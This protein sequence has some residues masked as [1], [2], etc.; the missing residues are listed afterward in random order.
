MSAAINSADE[1]TQVYSRSPV[2]ASL[3]T[4]LVVSTLLLYD[5]GKPF[6][7]HRFH[8]YLMLRYYPQVLNFDKEVDIL[9]APIKKHTD[10]DDVN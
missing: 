6:H 7:H 8:R 10:F 2:S 3:V 4:G 9:I 5:T 1:H